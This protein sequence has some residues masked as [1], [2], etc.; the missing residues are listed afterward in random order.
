M[1]AM[2][3][4]KPVISTRHTGIPEL[5]PEILVE[6][7][8]YRG[9]AEAILS[10]KDDPDLRKYMGENNRD[11]IERNYGPGNIEAMA[12]YLLED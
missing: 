2:A 7:N 1:E 10:L 6:E 3:Y 11:I 8:D 9:V 5:L 12:K 4:Q